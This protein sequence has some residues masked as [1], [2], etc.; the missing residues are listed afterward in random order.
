MDNIPYF[1]IAFFLLT[2]AVQI[3]VRRS[4]NGFEQMKKEGEGDVKG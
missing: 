2:L 1:M 3:M 4:N